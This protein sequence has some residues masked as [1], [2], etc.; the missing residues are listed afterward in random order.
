[1]RVSRE[2]ATILS[3]TAEFMTRIQSSGRPVEYGRK[4]KVTA[5]L[6]SD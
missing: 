5:K 4:L 6:E 3:G 1:V 2:V